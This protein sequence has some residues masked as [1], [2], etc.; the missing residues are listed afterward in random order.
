M[1]QRNHCELANGTNNRSGAQY[2]IWEAVFSPQG[3]DGYPKRLYDKL[4][5]EIAHEVAA[6]WREHFEG[7]RA[8]TLETESPRV[9]LSHFGTVATLSWSEQ[10]FIF[11]WR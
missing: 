4:T 9:D 5:G 7:E 2:D 8:L 3:E 6:Y 11:G 10:E 1:E